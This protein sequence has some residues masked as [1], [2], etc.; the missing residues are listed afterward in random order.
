MAEGHYSVRSQWQ[1]FGTQL[2]IV[3]YRDA[4]HEDDVEVGALVF[5]KEPNGLL[6]EPTFSGDRRDTLALLQ[7]LLEEA[8]KLGLRPIGYSEIKEQMKATDAHLQDM[9]SIVF[10]KMGAP[11]P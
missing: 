2:D 3:V 7:A 11:K 1:D 5:T 6:K 8:W 9:R 10:H 4:A